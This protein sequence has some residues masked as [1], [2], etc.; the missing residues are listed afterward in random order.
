LQIV[1][2]VSLVVLNVVGWL[3]LAVSVAKL[4][5]MLMR[6]PQK[7]PTRQDQILADVVQ[8]LSA[9]AAKPKSS[10]APDNRNSYQEN[11]NPLSPVYTRS[12]QH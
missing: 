2:E 10:V 8:W 9:G 7:V 3:A 12:P 11:P 1:A 6:P 4:L 5:T